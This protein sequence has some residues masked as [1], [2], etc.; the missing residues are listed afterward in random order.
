MGADVENAVATR[1]A[2]RIAGHFTDNLAAS[3]DD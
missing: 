2:A 1:L 3:A